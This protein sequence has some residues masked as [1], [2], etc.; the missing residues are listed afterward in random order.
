MFIHLQRTGSAAIH[1]RPDSLWRA[2]VVFELRNVADDQVRNAR[3]LDARIRG[4]V[5]ARLSGVYVI[6]P[7]RDDSN[8]RNLRQRRRQYDEAQ[9]R[10]AGRFGG[11]RGPDEPRMVSALAALQRSRMVDAQ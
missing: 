11:R 1:A 4:Y 2:A 5:V 8:V 7:Q 6:E 9:G 3:R 10:S